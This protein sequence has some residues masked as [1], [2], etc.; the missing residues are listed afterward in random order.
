M[1][2]VIGFRVADQE[3]RTRPPKHC[4]L[5]EE[6]LA[7]MWSIAV[8]KLCFQL[9][10]GGY[11]RKTYWKILV[12]IVDSTVHPNQCPMRALWLICASWNSN[13]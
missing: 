4:T 8:Q 7:I 11:C 1:M 6:I 10:A 12:Y 3:Q 2:R 13:G 5:P 9:T